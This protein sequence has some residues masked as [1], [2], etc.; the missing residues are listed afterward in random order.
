MRYI[1]FSCKLVKFIKKLSFKF[2]IYL[3]FELVDTTRSIENQ[4]S[5]QFSDRFDT[6]IINSIVNII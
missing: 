5:N 1:K 2:I 4:L 6:K 3:F